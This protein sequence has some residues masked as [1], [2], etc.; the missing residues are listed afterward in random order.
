MQNTSTNAEKKLKAKDF[1]TLG[2][3]TVLFIVIF[4]VCIMVMS[5]SPVTQPFGMALTALLAGPVYMLMR[6]KVN[7]FGGILISGIIF[8][9]VMFITGAGWTVALAVIIGTIIAELISRAGQYKKYWVSATGYAVFMT[10]GAIGSYTPLLMM[11]EY[12]TSL[13][14]ANSLDAAFMQELM[15]FVSGPVLVGAFA[16]TIACAFLG[17]LLA[18]AMFKKHFVKAGIISEVAYGNR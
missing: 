11:K 8:A 7:K 9:I 5:L 4:F 18:R 3:F 12:Y 6:A 15:D 16:A 10:A 14:A 1:I 17:A 2:I 13:S